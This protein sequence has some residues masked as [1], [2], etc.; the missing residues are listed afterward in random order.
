M[1]NL[2]KNLDKILKVSSHLK[3]L[4]K[5]PESVS[6][7]WEDELKC[8]LDMVTVIWEHLQQVKWPPS[9]IPVIVLHGQCCL[10]RD[11]LMEYN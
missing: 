6:L 1:Q 5:L 7:W 8:A 11:Y 2:L 3:W 9:E 4:L 10:Y